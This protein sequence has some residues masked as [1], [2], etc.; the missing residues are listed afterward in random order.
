MLKSVKTFNFRSVFL[1]AK[2]KKNH[3]GIALKFHKTTCHTL[4]NTYL[5]TDVDT[6]EL[7]EIELEIEVDALDVKK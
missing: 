4:I 6:L 1:T 3:R 7:N 2:Q 5:D